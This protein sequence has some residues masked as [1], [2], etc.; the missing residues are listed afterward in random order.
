MH[1]HVAMY[2]HTTWQRVDV[3]LGVCMCVFVYMCASLCVLVRT[4]EGGYKD[5]FL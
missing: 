1:R 2:G 4:C 5:S 3:D